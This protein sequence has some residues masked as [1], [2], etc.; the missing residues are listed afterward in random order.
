[1][2]MYT[3][4]NNRIFYSVL[5][6]DRAL[7]FSYWIVLFSYFIGRGYLY[8]E[9]IYPF[10][11]PSS[12]CKY[13]LKPLQHGISFKIWKERASFFSRE[14][15]DILWFCYVMLVYKLTILLWSVQSFLKLS[16]LVAYLY[17]T[18]LRRLWFK[19]GRSGFWLACTCCC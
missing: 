6:K 15:T 19:L 4:I 14:I 12:N 18:S 8:G 2:I 3:W 10:F 16:K 5:H 7:V 9:V 11:S 1:M 13:N 17:V